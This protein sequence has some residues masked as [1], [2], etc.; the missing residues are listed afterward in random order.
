MRV[1][2][3]LRRLPDGS[4]GMEQALPAD[5]HGSLQQ[6]VHQPPRH[7]GDVKQD[8]NRGWRL[9]P[10]LMVDHLIDLCV[11]QYC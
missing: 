4:P 8:R 10:V 3:R 5:G 11:Y 9:L 1:S 7:P 6:E 2:R